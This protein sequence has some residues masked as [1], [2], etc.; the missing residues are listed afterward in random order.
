[1]PVKKRHHWFLRL[2][3]LAWALTILLGTYVLLTVVL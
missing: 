1:M 2:I 3:G